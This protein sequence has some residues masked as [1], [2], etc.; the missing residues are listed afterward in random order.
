[1]KYN[2]GKKHCAAMPDRAVAGVS[3]QMWMVLLF[4]L[5]FTSE[6]K[7][8]VFLQYQF[9]EE[10]G[11]N[12]PVGDI[13]SDA[14]LADGT[15]KYVI[16]PD[17]DVPFPE[18]FRVDDTGHLVTIKNVDRD[19]LS[20]SSYSACLIPLQIHTE[21]T[22]TVTFIQVEVEVIDINDNSPVFPDPVVYLPLEENTHVDTLLPLPIATDPDSVEY[23]ILDYQ[24]LQSVD[25]FR[26]LEYNVTL[27]PEYVYMVLE[28]SLDREHVGSYQFTLLAT[29][30]G[31]PARTGST[32]IN[33]TVVDINDNLPE[34]ENQTYEVKIPED[35]ADNT[36]ILQ[37]KATD[38]DTGE[39]GKIIYSFSPKTEADYGQHFLIDHDTGDIIVLGNLDYD[40]GR[41]R[42]Y[43]TVRA[44]NQGATTFPGSAV[45]LVILHDVN[46][47]APTVKV[48]ALGGQGQ[49]WV[50]E[51][52]PNGTLVGHMTAKDK[53]EGVNGLFQCTL[54]SD[55]FT[56]KEV[57]L[58]QSSSKK[59]TLY[60]NRE[61][62]R[63][64]LPKLKIEIIC[65][66]FGELTKSSV[67]EEYV[68]IGD[69]NDNSPYFTGQLFN[70]SIM[71]NSPP[72]TQIIKI[73]ANDADEGDN[74]NI[75]Y[76][77]VE[78][79]HS[80]YIG[81]N[82]ITGDIYS[83]VRLDR[84][85]TAVFN[86][87]VTARDHG[88]P[89]RLST[90]TMVQIIVGDQDDYIPRFINSTYTFSV[91][92]NRQVETRIGTVT[93]VD[94][95]LPPY[96]DFTYSLLEDFNQQNLF[97]INTLNGDLLT[98]AVL[99]REDKDQYTLVAVVESLGIPKVSA[100]ATINIHVM[101]VND[102]APV[103]V[104]PGG[105]NNTFH[106]LG[107]LL[108]DGI[109]TRVT[110]TDADAG[111][112]AHIVYSIES[113]D[114]NHL[115]FVNPE[116]GD[117]RLLAEV[118]FL[119]ED[120]APESYTLLIQAK[121]MGSPPKRSSSK[122]ELI[123][124]KTAIKASSPDYS[125]SDETLSKTNLTIIVVICS[126]TG[127]LIILLIIL[128]LCVVRRHRKSKAR[129]K[130]KH[131]IQ[132]QLSTR[133][134][135]GSNESIEEKN[136]NAD[137]GSRKDPQGFINQALNLDR[138][139]FPADPGGSMEQQ[140]SHSFSCSFIFCNPYSKYKIL[141]YFYPR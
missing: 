40:L 124:N 92:E 140:V 68:Y 137:Q 4:F 50:M 99:D 111:G 14:G 101:D 25:T 27:G 120:S 83:R 123:L 2:T 88:H 46:D 74:A 48:N 45:V 59:Y 33:I 28:R 47:N 134:A 32:I 12:F 56:M 30:G 79:P 42:F 36:V 121:D 17:D 141:F 26:L 118:S 37:V 3:V 44:Q 116:T 132:V 115:F 71:E 52:A 70:A 65:E 31:T 104:F 94:L 76:T 54:E 55:D 77:L 129:R 41:K 38:K 103:F 93:A 69:V 87:N 34:F 1:M 90:W 139:D 66:D 112:N 22:D 49:L 106:V 19:S 63:E 23:S 21:L 10:T 91:L 102:E 85:E 58:G 84:E 39:H 29:D 108:K 67:T 114:D 136:R 9:K 60:S 97:R 64:T 107:P 95:D 135:L 16:D 80:Q 6:V 7:A 125:P 138:Q 78:G 51:N 117:L 133:Q 89:V 86:I 24:L 73:V 15:V 119:V 75:T 57:E 35:T 72:D 82:A 130:Y 81:I 105:T 131:A 122:L 98:R 62:D 8:T 11:A 100:S 53:D 109:V 61:F 127:L 126:I 113:G 128:I 20:C 18:L 43:L 13:H 110:A 5:M 96:N